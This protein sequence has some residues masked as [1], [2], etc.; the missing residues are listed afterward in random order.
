[1]ILQ[2]KIMNNMKNLDLNSMGVQ[3]MDAL[4]TKETD[5]GWFLAL[6]F[7]YIIVEAACNPDAHIKAFKEGWAR[8]N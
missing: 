2:T 3:K 1:M 5:G 4:E 7:T 6:A 8:A